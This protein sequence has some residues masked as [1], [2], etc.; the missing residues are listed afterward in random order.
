MSSARF[1]E[2]NNF[3]GRNFLMANPSLRY[4]LLT[5]DFLNGLNFNDILSSI[6]LRSGGQSTPSTCLLFEHSRFQGRI[7]AFAYNADRDIN[8]LPDFNDL[9]SSVLMMD[10]DPNPNK[11]ILALRQLGGSQLNQAIDDALQNVSEGSRNGDVLLKFTIDL[12]EVSLFGV[13]LMLIEIPIKLHTPWPFSDYDAKIRY[14]VKLFIDSGH[15]LQ[16][17]V[18]AWGYWIEGGILTGSIESR[19]RPKVEEK[20]GTVETHLN[21]MLKEVNFHQWTD[22][23]LMPGA[24]SVTSDYDGNVADDCSVVLPFVSK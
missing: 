23:Y 3:A 22:V 7:K 24:A 19:L 12:F 20:I 2:H 15:R 6:Q 16:G 8:S 17:F 14:W 5:F 11:T 13:D 1:F 18:A 4:F 9:T 10:H 21:N